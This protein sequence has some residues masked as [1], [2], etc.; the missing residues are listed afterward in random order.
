MS[1]KVKIG[2]L[3]IGGGEKI[4]VQSM[5]TF[6]PSDI[7]NTINQ[8]NALKQAGCDIVRFSVQTTEDVNA[9]KIIKKS[10]DI[11]LVA[12]IH[13]DYKLALGAIESGVDKIRINPGNIGSDE[14]VKAV[15]SALKERGIPV[16]VGANTGSIEKE[17]YAKYGRNEISL[18]ESA[19][20]NVAVLEN[21]GVENIVISVKASDVNLM[22]K[23]YEYLATKTNYPLHLGVTEAGTFQSGVIKNSIGIGALLAKNIGDTIRVSLS[24]DPVLE[25][26]T[27][28]NILRALDIEKDFVDI[29]SCPT[30]GRCEWDCMA[31]AEEI[32]ALTKSVKKKLKV[33]IMGCVVNGPGEAKDADIGIAG[34]LDNAVIFKNGEIYKRVKIENAKEEF[35]KEIKNCLK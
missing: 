27:A 26:E 29:I 31:F 1:K 35:Y 20:K 9:I 25:V 12:D 17:F 15:A 28:K 23:S 14:N 5:T 21:Q 32:S 30:C 13:F 7:D 22:I 4:A 24:A 34:G 2:N 33:A 3:Y 16:R 10:T 6:K 19:L 11:P 18:V 8:I